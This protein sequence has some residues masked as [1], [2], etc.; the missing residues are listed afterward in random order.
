M[1][2]REDEQTGGRTGPRGQGREKGQR[3]L[4]RELPHI[5]HALAGGQRGR[6]GRAGK[7]VCHRGKKEQAW[8]RST[9]V[10]HNR[11]TARSARGHWARRSAATRCRNARSYNEGQVRACDM[12]AI[13]QHSVLQEVEG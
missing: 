5:V 8:G 9:K 12:R 2:T 13:C 7:R 4:Q 3:A 10:P 11:A 1:R 6:E